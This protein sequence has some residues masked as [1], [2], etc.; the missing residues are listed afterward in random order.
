[1]PAYS[2]IARAGSMPRRCH[3]GAPTKGERVVLAMV[4]NELTGGRDVRAVG[5]KVDAEGQASCLPGNELSAR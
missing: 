4:S 3:V 5:E 2:M 1:M